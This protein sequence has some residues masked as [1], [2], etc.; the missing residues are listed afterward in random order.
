MNIIKAMQYGIPIIATNIGAH[1]ELIND[2]INGL[3]I[4]PS[5]P[6]AIAA[7]IDMLIDNKKLYKQISKNSINK[8]AEYDFTQFS[9]KILKTL[10]SSTLIVYEI[11]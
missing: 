10:N 7:K 11:I 9:E 4:P 1:T 6:E 3:L 5:S 8:S 2:G